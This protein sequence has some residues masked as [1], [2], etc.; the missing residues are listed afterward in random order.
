MPLNPNHRIARLINIY[1]PVFNDC[2]IIEGDEDMTLSFDEALISGHF[3]NWLC[4]WA[5]QDRRGELLELL[6]Y[7]KIRE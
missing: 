4:E 1:L 6:H 3:K 5:D 7:G 2:Q